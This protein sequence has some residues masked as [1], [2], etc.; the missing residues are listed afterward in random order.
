MENSTSGI[1]CV[2]TDRAAIVLRLTNQG[3]WRPPI[4]RPLWR[5]ALPFFLGFAESAGGQRVGAW[6]MPRRL[7]TPQ[8][9]ESG[10]VGPSPGG[11]GVWRTH[12]PD[13]SQPS[14]AVGD[15]ACS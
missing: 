15:A 4:P 8:I 9:Q 5:A 13:N 6:P 14:V 3:G 11:S 7:R 1:I 2:L 12:T 10:A